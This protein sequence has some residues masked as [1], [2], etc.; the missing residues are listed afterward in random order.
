MVGE[1]KEGGGVGVKK[2]M[3]NGQTGRDVAGEAARE[4]DTQGGGGRWRVSWELAYFSN[5]CIR[6]QSCVTFMPWNKSALPK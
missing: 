1:N 4:R 2:R 3:I 6:T 5:E